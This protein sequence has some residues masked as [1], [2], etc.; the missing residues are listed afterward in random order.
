MKNLII[1]SLKNIRNFI[2]SFYVVPRSMDHLE[3]LRR[4]ELNQ[5]LKE[6][7]NKSK[8]LEVG[9]GAGW[10]SKILSD[11]GYKVSAIDIVDT[12]YKNEQIFEVIDY[13][14]HKIP[15]EDKSFDIVFSSNV[16]EHIPHIVDFQKEIKRVLKDDGICIH[17]LPSSNWVFWTNIASVIKKFKPAPVHGEIASSNFTELY[18]FSRSYWDRLFKNNGFKV[19]KYKT[20]NLFY[21]GGSLMDYRWSIEKR[22][23][24]SKVLGSSCHFYVLE[25]ENR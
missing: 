21:T 20:N 17:L 18:Y 10:Q 12:I 23:S 9:A 13:D 3:A 15:F 4:E 24:L 8:I 5:V 11:Y 14:G 19:L 22:K 1:T 25:K 2:T 6:C 7:G 16:L